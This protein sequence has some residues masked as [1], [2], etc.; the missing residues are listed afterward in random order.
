MRSVTPVFASITTKST[1][2]VGRCETIGYCFGSELREFW[3]G[4]LLKRRSVMKLQHTL[5]CITG[6]FIAVGSTESQ[7][8]GPLPEC[9]LSIEINALR[10]GSPTVT[11]GD[12]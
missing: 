11:A 1:T 12:N 6:I 9:Q 4:L 7:A 3:I 8:G 5:I 2:V 10:A